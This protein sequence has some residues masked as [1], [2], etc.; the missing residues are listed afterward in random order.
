VKEDRTRHLLSLL[1]RLKPLDGQTLTQVC[2]TLDTRPAELLSD[3]ALLSGVRWKEKEEHE[4]IDVWIEG[5]RICVF[6]G[7]TLGRPLRFTAAERFALMH[8]AQRLAA[9]GVLGVVPKMHQALEKLEELSDNSFDHPL[10]QAVVV[11][12]ALADLELR[13][14][15]MHQ[16]VKQKT[17]L[18]FWYFS[19]ASDEHS[20]RR[21]YPARLFQKG[22]AWYLSAFDIDK[23]GWRVFKVDRADHVELV[24]NYNGTKPPPS[25]AQVQDYIA[26][27]SD[28]RAW[29]TGLNPIT[30]RAMV[31]LWGEVGRRAAES[32]WP[33][34]RRL[35]AQEQAEL[36][37]DWE[38]TP[39]LLSL[40]G[41][42][43]VLLKRLEEVRV[44]GPTELVD[45]LR[46]KMQRTLD[47]LKRRTQSQ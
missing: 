30:K 35:D 12:P 21:A 43:R 34:L 38:W 22:H 27:R 7:N 26:S 23:Q 13:L 3:I 15:C 5:D 40:D 1:A 41:V 9:Q 11:P 24:S 44:V 6:D 32:K 29:E 39:E 45:A 20:Q 19:V 33:D 28:E 2:K 4:T 36:E 10:E 17:L 46:E 47:K 31:Y 14:A 18:R 16:A 25:T 8:G 42:A 37:A